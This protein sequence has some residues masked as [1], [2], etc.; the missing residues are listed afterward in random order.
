MNRSVLLAVGLA[1]LLGA[2]MLAG[3][4]AHQANE[5]S[6]TIKNKMKV[7]VM[8]SSAQLIN[9]TISANG[10]AIPSKETTLRAEMIMTVEKIWVKEGTYVKKGDVLVSFNLSD[11]MARLHEAKTKVEDE[12][13]SLDAMSKLQ[14]R[15]FSAKTKYYE[16]KAELA[17]AKAKLI[18]IKIEVSKT[19]IIAPFDGVVSEI[20]VEEGDY[21]K[22]GENVADIVN[23]SPLLINVGIAQKSIS[24]LSKNDKANITLATG[25]KLK[26][27]VQFISPVAD[28]KT[29]MFKVEIIAPNPLKFRSGVSANV[30]ITTSKIKAHFISPALLSMNMAGQIGIKVVDKNSVVKFMPIVISQSDSKGLWISSLPEQL[31]II[32]V[33]QGFVEEGEEVIAI[34]AEAAHEKNH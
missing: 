33:G 1:G 32:T 18:A 24:T 20:Y 23:N 3:D 21:L 4:K 22:A 30:D 25:H 19:K 29:R 26:G 14:T 15:G 11:R 6:A 5:K 27:H 7:V 10:Q 8:P 28:N 16:T 34:Q 31:T 13:T 9:Q 2:W 17:K 12:Q